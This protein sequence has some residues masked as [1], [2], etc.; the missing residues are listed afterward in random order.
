MRKTYL[1][2]ENCHWDNYR[3]F[4]GHEAFALYDGIPDVV[5]GGWM[6]QTAGDPIS[7]TDLEDA[8]CSSELDEIKA[9]IASPS[10]PWQ[11]CD[12]KDREYIAEWAKIWN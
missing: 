3:Y 9:I 2:Y 7:E 6:L 12:D 4:S 10:T 11:E 5:Y 1:E 8:E